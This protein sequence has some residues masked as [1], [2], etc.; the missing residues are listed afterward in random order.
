VQRWLDTD[1]NAKSR[2]AAFFAGCGL[3][4]SQLAIN[5]ID[6]AFSAGMDI[7][8]L[9]PS[10]INIRRGAYIGLVLSIAL[11]PWQLLSSAATFISVLSAYSV[12][13]GPMTG[14]MICDY[15]VV[16]R[17]KLKLS[18]LYHGRKDGAFYFWHGINWRSFTAWVIGWSYLIPGFVKAVA[19]E[20][21]VPVAC[22]NL[23]YLAFPL[24]FA[25]SFVVYFALNLISRPEGV[26]DV[27]EVD[28]FN[29]FTAEEARKLGIA[30]SF[31]YGSAQLVD[32]GMPTDNG[33]KGE[34]TK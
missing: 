34:M 10:F 23:Y 33:R 22:T 30:P 27:D 6:N 19:P 9:F 1:Y 20:I 14:I 11:C 29:T 3:V 26:Q 13:L 16:R 5:T 12:F 15:W 21:D 25:V 31:I 8:G 28:E 17:A 4:T 24:G 2:A 18:D 32:D 7:A